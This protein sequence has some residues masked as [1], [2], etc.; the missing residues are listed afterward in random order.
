[1]ANAPEELLGLRAYQ[2][3]ALGD[4]KAAALT[5]LAEN[6]HRRETFYASLGMACG[7]LCFLSCVLAFA[8]LVMHAHSTEAYVVLGTAVLALIGRMIAA[9]LEKG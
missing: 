5:Q 7:T 3:A 6:Y 2:F 8:Y 9:R 4:A 1:M